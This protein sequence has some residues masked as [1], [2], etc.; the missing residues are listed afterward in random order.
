MLRFQPCA[1]VNLEVR[2]GT[3]RATFK[4]VP[5]RSVKVA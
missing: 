3:H 2:R 1:D 4:E 5:E